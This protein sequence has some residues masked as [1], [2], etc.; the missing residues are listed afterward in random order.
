MHIIIK[1]F[2]R[3]IATIQSDVAST[4]Y[5]NIWK[6]NPDAEVFIQYHG[7]EA[8]YGLDIDGALTGYYPLTKG[9]VCE[10]IISNINIGL[11]TN[12]LIE[13]GKAYKIRKIVEEFLG[14]LGIR[15]FAIEFKNIEK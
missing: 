7:E 6:L 8:A 11:I 12:E 5:L 9:L 13:N 3:G 10:V 14:S 15:F 4:L 2:P 1:Y